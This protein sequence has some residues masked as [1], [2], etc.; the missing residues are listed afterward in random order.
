M[1]NLLQWQRTF[2]ASVLDAADN[3]ALQDIA[4]TTLQQQR[5]NVY[6]NNVVHSLIQA[7]ASLY[8]V[9]QQLIG[10][11]TFTQLA[12][13]FIPDNLPSH[14]TLIR[15][16]GDF[17][18]FLERSIQQHPALQAVGYLPDVAKLE[19]ALHLAYHATD[20]PVLK[21]SDLAKVAGEQLLRAQLNL[22]A[23]VQLLTSPHPIDAIWQA[24]QQSPPAVAGIVFDGS[25]K[26]ILALRCHAAVEVRTLQA[27]DHTFLCYCNQHTMQA[28]LEYTLQQHPSFDLTILLQSVLFDGTI[29]SISFTPG[30]KLPL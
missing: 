29:S 14:G 1:N 8:P 30:G 28:A 18:A 11:T 24:H 15:Y 19:Y 23:S 6:R 26:H 21:P 3:T 25:T 27:A 22:H 20:D 9:V 13:A 2:A 16:G 5:L 10:K 17:V 7:L 12:Q 4:N